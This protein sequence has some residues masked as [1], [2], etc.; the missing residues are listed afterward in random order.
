MHLIIKKKNCTKKYLF[1][2]IMV[3]LD[4]Y[5]ICYKNELFQTTSYTKYIIY[6]CS[7]FFHLMTQRVILRQM[8]ECDFKWSSG[9]IYI[10][11]YICTHIYTYI[12]I[13]IYLCINKDKEILRISPIRVNLSCTDSNANSS[14]N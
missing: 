12:H 5:I 14:K 2:L 4:I 10:Y 9:H 8:V 11:L 7:F 1:T 3:F 13:N 6:I